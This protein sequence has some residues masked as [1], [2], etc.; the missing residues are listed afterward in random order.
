MYI[1]TATRDGRIKIKFTAPLI[2]SIPK[3][4]EAI[5]E[6]SFLIEIKTQRNK[7]VAYNVT[8]KDA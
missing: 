1:K 2:E 5:D 8:L 3:L 6:N 4:I 7:R